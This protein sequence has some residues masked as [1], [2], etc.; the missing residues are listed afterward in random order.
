MLFNAY[1]FRHRAI[2]ELLSEAAQFA[3]ASYMT[4]TPIE[5]DYVLDELKHLPICEIN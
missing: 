3:R 5:R 1:S 4:A 2:K